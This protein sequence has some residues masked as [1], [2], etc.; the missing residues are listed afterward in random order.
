MSANERC[1]PSLIHCPNATPNTVIADSA[2]RVAAGSVTP[3]ARSDWPMAS[4]SAPILCSSRSCS[5]GFCSITVWRV[6]L[7]DRAL[8][9]EE[10]RRR[11]HRGRHDLQRRASGRCGL[12][13]LEEDPNQLLL[14]VEQH[15][16]LVAE[17][18][19]E[20]ALGQPD[21]RAMSAAVVWSNPCSGEESRA[22]ACSRSSRAGLPSPHGGEPSDDSD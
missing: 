9:R 11:L 8:V 6:R 18:A 16:A 17:V 5:A 21:A 20:R 22:A 2:A 7:K 19:E 1:S 13:P 10:R 4:L 3:R 12:D 14:P 15:L